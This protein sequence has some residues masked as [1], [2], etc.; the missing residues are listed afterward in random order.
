MDAIAIY[1]MSKGWQLRKHIVLVEGTSDEALFRL[2]DELL[3][4]VGIELLGEE[5]SIVA[6]GEHDRGG[7]FGVG[8][9]LITLRSMAPYILDQDGSLFIGQLVWS[10][11]IM[12]GRESSSTFRT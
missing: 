11:T 6:A 10:I 12:Q 7:T 1:G 3:R 8:R 2:A 4:P 9:E 5:I